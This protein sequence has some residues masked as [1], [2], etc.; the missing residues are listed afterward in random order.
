MT[1]NTAILQLSKTFTAQ[2]VREGSWGSSAIGEHES[3]MNLYIYPDLR[4]YIEWDIASIDTV[5]EI[6]LIFELDADRNLVLTDY[7]GVFSLP[8]QAIELLREAK[9][10][11]NQEFE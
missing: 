8:A 4:G 5:E 6:G 9:V 2:L 10:I 7:D 11:V 1:G 3:T